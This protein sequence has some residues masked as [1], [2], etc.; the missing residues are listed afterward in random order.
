MKISASNPNWLTRHCWKIIPALAL[1]FFVLTSE[2]RIHRIQYV[3]Y[4]AGGP[5]EG[6][7]S[8]PRLIIPGHRSQSF[9][10]LDQTRLMLV[11]RELRVRRIDYENAPYGREVSASSPYRWWLGALA[12]YFG[13]VSGRN[14]AASIE[15]AAQVSD[16]L[17]LV[18]FGAAAVVFV[19]RRFGAFA[20]SLLSVGL[21]TQYPFA[22][23]FL[24][25]V[26]DDSGMALLCSLLSVLPIV[27]CSDPT[28]GGRQ[29]RR[30][31]LTAGIIGGV[32][33]WINVAI[34]V[35]ILIGI[36]VGALMAAW[37]ARPEVGGK[38]GG[39]VATPLRDWALGGAVASFT[40]YLIEFF[41]GHMDSWELRTIHPSL[42]LAWL[43]GGEILIFLVD[44]IQR[45]R[46]R[47]M[48]ADSIRI[49]VAVGAVAS[50]PVILWRTHSWGFLAVD[51][52]SMTL[53]AMPGAVS[54]RNFWSLLL[55]NG[56]TPTVCVTFLPFFAALIVLLLLAF[57]WFPPERRVVLSY[58]LGLALASFTFAFWQ[59]GFWNGADVAI[60]VLFVTASAAFQDDQR[61][62]LRQWIFGF[63]AA[64]TMLPGAVLLWPATD[65]N[66]RSELSG[67]EIKSLVERDLAHWLAKRVGSDEAV[68]L[69]PPDT[70]NSLYYYGGMK[71]IDTFDWEN[72]EGVGGAVRI[73]SASTPEEAQEL[74][75]QRGITY[76]V[77][78]SWDRYMDAYARMGEGEL[79][80]T[81]LERLRRW[82]LPPWLRPV[83][84][85][86]PTIAGF[87]GQAVTILEVV[88]PQNDAA[89]ASHIAEYFADMGETELLSDA[90]IQL[91]RF[92]GD[93]GAL[94]ARA[95]IAASLARTD[96]FDQTIEVLVHRNSAPAIRTLAWDQRVRLAIIFARAKHLDLARAHLQRCVDTI[97]ERKLRSLSTKA[98][99]RLRMMT[100]A[101][102]IEIADP[103][104]R[105]LS[106]ELLPLD[107]QTR[108]EHR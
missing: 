58:A 6:A 74:I 89:A 95:E 7:G 10:W 30:A 86:M 37:I 31:F 93:I 104:M 39:T 3:S 78:P 85:L 107:L 22:S 46:L 2:I 53:S 101:F 8:L 108:L 73:M 97:D 11:K 45:R 1:F 106:I 67:S 69:S 66:S 19:A 72:R 88:E 76:I 26:P 56:F 64:I 14:L 41:P 52:P 79:E 49:V 12:L 75:G 84:Y 17:L 59:I 36:A 24:P 103:S 81:F 98:L 27:A 77:M 4:E 65:S 91:R 28:G 25:G 96:E 9:E 40:G 29:T 35:P 16:P 70:T 20:A 50:V 100:N 47:L 33:L 61:I 42:C 83:A 87:E 32:G 23:E 90:S 57:R 5:T 48:Y 13:E 55:Q 44:Q 80:G 82:V 99:F 63:I 105:G 51:L 71:G 18:L 68:V 102:G 34:E 92:P 15:W 62:R 43:G 54:A 60:L 94:L 38:P 21:V